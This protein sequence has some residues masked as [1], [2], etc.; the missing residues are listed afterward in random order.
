MGG[1]LAAKVLTQDSPAA[2]LQRAVDAERVHSM[3]ST[4]ELLPRLTDPFCGLALEHPEL[5]GRPLAFLYTRLFPRRGDLGQTLARVMPSACSLQSRAAGPRNGRA[6][7]QAGSGSPF[8]FAPP[9]FIFCDS[10]PR[11]WVPPLGPS[12]WRD[13]Q[14]PAK[15]S[16][17]R[18][19]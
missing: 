17:E 8:S 15:G 2:V 11:P 19:G 16:G 12:P 9:P 18:A 5:G 3:A 10:L 1:G 14:R 6:A 13:R 4:R 7:H